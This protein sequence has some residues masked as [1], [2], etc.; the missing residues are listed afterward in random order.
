MERG[1]D[2]HGPR[3]DEALA[4]EVEGL[5][6]AGRDTHA[7]EWAS[8][9]PSGEDQPDVDRAPHGTL[10]G[11]VPD[12]MTEEDVEQRS[13][14]ATYLGKE[15]WPATG[16]QLVA[17]A[18]ARQ[19]PDDVVAQLSYLHEGRSYVNMQEAWADLQGGVEQHRS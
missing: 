1:S 12:G 14:L 2:K 8:P 15:V 19:A 5:L 16:A 7:E 3:M 4:H 6:H 9:E 10:H 18:R 11:A 13:R 17:V